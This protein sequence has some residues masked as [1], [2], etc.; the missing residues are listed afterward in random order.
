MSTAM[1]H[2]AEDIEVPNQMEAHRLRREEKDNIHNFVLLEGAK[3][4]IVCAAGATTASFV[5]QRYSTL[6]RGLSLPFKVFLVMGA[7]T[8]GFFT[9]TDRAAWQADREFMKNFSVSQGAEIDGNSAL[10]VSQ[11]WDATRIKDFAI[12]NKYSLLG[13][14]YAAIVGTTLAYNF[15][16]RDIFMTQKSIHR[17]YLSLTRFG[18]GAAVGGVLLIGLLAGTEGGQ[19]KE[20]VD[21]YYER[22]VNG[23]QAKQ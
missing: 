22:I 5:A 4:A 17:T 21:P 23:T 9:E 7:T 12:K 10:P 19:R 2:I 1:G 14:S 11:G 18:T 20:T 6:Y 16:R 3:T 15:T 13:Y 8:A